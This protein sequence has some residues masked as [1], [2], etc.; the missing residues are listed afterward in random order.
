[1]ENK[2]NKYSKCVRST[3]HWESKTTTNI[4]RHIFCT[5]VTE[6]LY[7]DYGHSIYHVSWTQKPVE[8]QVLMWFFVSL[9]DAINNYRRSNSIKPVYRSRP[10]Q[11]LSPEKSACN[12]SFT[13][14]SSYSKFR[15]WEQK[16]KAHHIRMHWT[17]LLLLLVLSL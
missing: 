10:L 4:L 9:N 11:S 15:A 7:W 13:T 8:V 3:K 1:M 6:V 5:Q 12:I 2:N 17:V 14:Y 16:H